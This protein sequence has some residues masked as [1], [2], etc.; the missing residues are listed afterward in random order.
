MDT[1]M[2]AVLS[3]TH[4]HSRPNVEWHGLGAVRSI[5]LAGAH[6]CRAVSPL[7]RPF[8]E[9]L[10]TPMLLE[11][12]RLSIV[13]ILSKMLIINALAIVCSQFPAFLSALRVL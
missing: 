2:Y 3:D 12:S 8:G 7:E 13:D 9:A 5:V 11:L 4:R 6:R 10:I 1:V